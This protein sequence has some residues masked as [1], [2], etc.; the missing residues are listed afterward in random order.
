[1]PNIPRVPSLA[2]FGRR[3]RCLSRRPQ[4]GRRPKPITTPD[5]THRVAISN[6]RLIKADAASVTFKVKNYRVKGPARY[7]SMTL[8]TSEFIRRFLT[9]ILPQGF[10]RIRHYGLLA[11]STKAERIATAHKLL[12][13]PVPSVSAEANSTAE[14]ADDTLDPPCPCCGGRM[15]IIEVFQRGQTPRHK[16]SPHPIAIRIDTS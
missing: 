12:G 8:A 3:P 7:T 6:S 9:H 5:Y 4:W 16:P 2:A 13:M 15:R 1:V 10:H 11:G 14:A